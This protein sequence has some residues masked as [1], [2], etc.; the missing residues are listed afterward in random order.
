MTRLLALVVPALLAGCGGGLAA[1]H[2]LTVPLGIERTAADAALKHHQYCI[3]VDGPRP[4]VETY[5]RCARAGF[6]WGESWVSATYKDNKLVE[7]RRYERIAD[8]VRAT[9][10][11]NQLVGE[12][13]K[14]GDASTEA[15][16]AIRSRLLE[17]GTRTL[18]A[19]RI[20]ANT[21]V[22]IYLLNPKPPE[23]ANILEAV[24]TI[25]RS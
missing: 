11:W 12:R 8:G 17:P 21:V 5:P 24:L 19:F 18:K 22:G 16:A 2:P 13:A 9:E 14:T 4:D 1:E 10:R 15:T 3:K 25:P 7:L 20:D 23:E 6:E